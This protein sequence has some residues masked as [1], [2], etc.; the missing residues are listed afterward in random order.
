MS[1]QL[2]LSSFAEWRGK[3]L[4]SSDGVEI[5]RIREV[6]YDYLTG[7]PIGMGVGERIVNLRV[8]AR[9]ARLEGDQVRC[10]FSKD[11]IEN[12]PPSDFGRGFANWSEERRLY[13][14][15][16]VVLDHE[17]ELRVLLEGDDLPG[18]VRYE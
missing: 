4:V 8:P 12:Q 3:T 9:S 6:V 5:G 11:Q 1:E 14:Y 7:E 13:E 2:S 18:L 15:F 17:P 10:E 16:G